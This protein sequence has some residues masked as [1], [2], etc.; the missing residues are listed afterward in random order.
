MVGK[1]S[2]SPFQSVLTTNLHSDHDHPLQVIEM[3][4]TVQK[5]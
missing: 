5:L 1:I 2:I 3:S 4:L